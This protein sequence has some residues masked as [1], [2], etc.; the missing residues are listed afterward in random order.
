MTQLMELRRRA[1]I[2]R[3][4]SGSPIRERLR[5][6]PIGTNQHSACAFVRRCQAVANASF[7]MSMSRDSRSC[8]TNLN[9]APILQ[10][11]RLERATGVVYRPESERVSHYFPARL[12]DQCDAVV[13]RDETQALHPLE[14]WSRDEL[15][16]PETCPSAL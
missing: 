13:H 10:P 3:D 5:P 7:M 1:A 4:R 9:S 11:S 6:P 8:S 16:L 12:A 2:A 14:I 15:D